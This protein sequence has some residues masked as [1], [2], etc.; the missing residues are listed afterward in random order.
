MSLS[1][2]P[3]S[4][5]RPFIRRDRGRDTTGFIG[6]FGEWNT[7]PF[8]TFRIP[9]CANSP[10]SSASNHQILLPEI[11]V[12]A[13]HAAPSSMSRNLGT[14]PYDFGLLLELDL[15]ISFA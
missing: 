3:K 2:L 12:G 7:A 11:F 10:N 1:Y 5:I 13:Q 6:A 15:G 4:R 8:P 9:T 14:R